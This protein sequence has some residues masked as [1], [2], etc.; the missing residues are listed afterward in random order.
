MVGGWQNALLRSICLCQKMPVSRHSLS[1][2]DSDRPTGAA[3]CYDSVALAVYNNRQDVPITSLNCA[4]R[5]S[6]FGAILKIRMQMPHEDV[7]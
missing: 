4:E 6:K 5:Y 3:C 2:V 7:D 1:S